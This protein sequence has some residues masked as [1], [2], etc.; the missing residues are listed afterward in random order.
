MLL[1]LLIKFEELFDGTLVDW[2][3]EPV[4]FGLKEGTKPYMM[5]GCSQY[6]SHAKKQLSKN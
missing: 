1:E 6:Q 5:T 2:N 4:F 3:T